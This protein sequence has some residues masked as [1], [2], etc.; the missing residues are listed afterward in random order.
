MPAKPAATIAC[1]AA[2]LATRATFDPVRERERVFALDAALALP[3]RVLLLLAAR[4]DLAVER[5]VF[6]VMRLVAFPRFCFAR[7]VA[8]LMRLAM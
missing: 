5:F 7:V 2:F 8:L 3:T 4:V 6:L 1:E